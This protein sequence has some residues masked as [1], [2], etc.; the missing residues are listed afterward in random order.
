M[1]NTTKT[2]NHDSVVIEVKNLVEKY[3]DLR[4]ISYSFWLKELIINKNASQL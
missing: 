4:L 3:K 2:H 1:E